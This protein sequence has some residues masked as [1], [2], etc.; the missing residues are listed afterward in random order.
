[1]GWLVAIGLSALGTAVTYLWP[2]AR[3]FGYFLLGIGALAFA[4]A[5]VGAAVAISHSLKKNRRWRMILGLCIM[6]AG[7]V[8][9]VWGLSIFA[10][11]GFAENSPAVTSDDSIGVSVYGLGSMFFQTQGNFEAPFSPADSPVLVVGPFDLTNLSDS[12][13]KA[14]DVYIV[15]KGDTNITARAV[16]RNVP[17]ITSNISEFRKAHPE[18]KMTQFDLNQDMMYPPIKLAASETVRGRVGFVFHP[19]TGDM[20]REKLHNHSGIELRFV[21][22]ASGKTQ[23]FQVAASRKKADEAKK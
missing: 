12:K 3:G 6:C 19:G 17:G 13:P 8:I 7:M 18:M 14:I 2:G 1:V 23:A 11:G 15:I 22:V 10:S 9:G 16:D 21:D 20:I 4:V 5:A